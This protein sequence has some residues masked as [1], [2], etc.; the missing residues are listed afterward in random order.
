MVKIANGEWIADLGSMSCWN[1]VNKI[2]VT[3]EKSGKTLIGKINDI[4]IEL[5][6]KWAAEPQG[7]RHIKKAVM[8]AEEA[9]LR[10]YFDN[11]AKT[12]S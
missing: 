9:F 5:M 7:E 10:A 3:F 11:N 1:C 12:P 2:V 6:K 8:E 4:P